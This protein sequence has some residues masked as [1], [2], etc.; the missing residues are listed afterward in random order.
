[1]RVVSV[2]PP[3]MSIM[4][5][6]VH[7][8]RRPSWC[9]RFPGVERTGLLRHTKHYQRASVTERTELAESIPE[10]RG[11]GIRST[12]NMSKQ[13]PKQRSRQRTPNNRTTTEFRLSNELWAVLHRLLPVHV[14]MHRFGAGRPRVPDRRCADA[15]FYVLR[16]GWECASPGPDRTMCTFDGPRSVSSVGASRRLSQIMAGRSRAV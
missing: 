7:S 15:I 1:L 6:E 8:L 5:E 10:N 4:H 3:V 14:K 2:T 13:E 11:D 12:G 9:S 16:T